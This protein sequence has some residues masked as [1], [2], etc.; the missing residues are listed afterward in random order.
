M[1]LTI[2]DRVLIMNEVL[3]QFDTMEGIATK[4]AIVEKLK[5]SPTE[6]DMLVCNRLPN[7]VMEIGF[8]DASGMTET[9]DIALTEDE[10]FYIKCKVKAIDRNGMISADNITTYQAVLGEEFTDPVFVAKWDAL[11]PVQ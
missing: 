3:P 8:K 11:Y 6:S 1:E 9:S 4:M 7:G 2:K 10:L 5:L